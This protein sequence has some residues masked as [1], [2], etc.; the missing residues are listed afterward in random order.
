[1]KCAP[2]SFFADSQNRLILTILDG[3]ETRAKIFD[4]LVGLDTEI[5][6]SG[7]VGGIFDEFG[8]KIVTR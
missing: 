4:A 6:A 5:D 1:M 3:F 8:S 2:D 7:Y